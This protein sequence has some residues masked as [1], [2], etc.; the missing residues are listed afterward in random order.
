MKKGKSMRKFV[1]VVEGKADKQ[2]L[3]QYLKYKFNIE[4]TDDDILTIGGFQKVHSEKDGSI[5]I[6]N[7]KFKENNAKGGVNLIVFDADDDVENRRKELNKCITEKKWNCSLFLIPDNKNPG[8]LEDLLEQIICPVNRPIFDCWGKY[9]N[10]LR[11]VKIKGR[12][13]PLT[14]P[15][16][17]T[18]IYAYLEVLLGTSCKQKELIKES[19]RD[20]LNKDHWDLDNKKLEP[21]FDFIKGE[22]NT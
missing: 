8:A 9:E 12:Q 18:K 14:I 5:Q 15:A 11:K 1:I 7:N 6:I 10:L 3:K 16:K 22:I 20:Y 19:N 21:L 17:K 4:T 13:Q 2:F